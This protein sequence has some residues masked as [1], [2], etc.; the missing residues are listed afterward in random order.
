MT[1]SRPAFNPRYYRLL[2][3]DDVPDNSFLVQSILASQGYRVEVA[4]TGR[5]ALRR[6][7]QDPPDL[8]LL[9]VMM[10][11]I[12]GYEVTRSV[13]QNSTLPFI[14]ILLITAYDQPSVVKGLDL[15]ADDF[16]RKPL[17]VDELLARVRCLLRLKQSIDARDHIARQREDFVSRLTH[18]LRT[19]LI[20]A[21]RMLSLLLE[22]TLGPL[23]MD[24]IGALDLLARSNKN[25][26]ELVNKLLQVYRF[27]SGDRTLNFCAVNLTNLLSEVVAELMPLVQDKGLNLVQK[28]DPEFPLIEGDPLELRRVVTNLVG[29]SIQYTQQGSI[30]LTLAVVSMGQISAQPQF[31]FFK[32]EDTGV[33]IPDRQRAHL[34]EPFYAGQTQSSGSGLGLYLSRYI[35][36]AHRGSITVTS[37][38]GQGSCFTVCLPVKQNNAPG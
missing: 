21:D 20:A 27:E 19:P 10:P 29:N 13:R 3:V 4:S 18:D 26:L 1:D 30:T 16:V 17:E 14:P 24:V 38:P 23:N 34:F 28:I 11:D 5:E 7:E 36:E 8:V 32:V 9:D 35:V 31:I 22:E 25:L 33:G 12:D 37:T 2:V 15:G 6:I